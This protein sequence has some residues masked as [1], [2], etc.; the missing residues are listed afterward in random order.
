MVKSGNP[1]E[2]IPQEKTNKSTKNK[3]T[4]KRKRT[5]SQSSKISHQPSSTSSHSEN[6]SSDSETESQ[7]HNS[8]PKEIINQPTSNQQSPADLQPQNNE[9]Q[10]QY[11]NWE[12][13]QNNNYPESYP[14][15]NAQNN[16][17]QQS[18][19][20]QQAQNNNFVQWPPP[21][22]PYFLQHQLRNNRQFN[23]EPPKR[24]QSPYH[25]HWLLQGLLQKQYEKNRIEHPT[26][27]QD[28]FVFNFKNDF[29]R[30]FIDPET[31]IT[32]VQLFRT[33]CFFTVE[34]KTRLE[35]YYRTNLNK[36]HT[37]THDYANPSKNKLFR[38]PTPICNYSI[39]NT[40][41]T[42]QNILEHCNHFH[43]QN[44][45]TYRYRDNDEYIFIE[46]KPPK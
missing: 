20:W 10:Q 27:N 23:R 9:H 5:R 39:I 4:S 43:Q 25:A 31:N 17:Q 26:L 1:N 3:K 24:P 13:D 40:T 30:I 29:G 8:Y 6:S 46:Y 2:K 44:P 15:H 22:N 34:E 12:Q 35:Q 28:D 7:S 37:D 32:H 36:N 38:C 45:L 33:S 41:N 11:P 18:F 21:Q 14:W 19:L 42:S 16:N